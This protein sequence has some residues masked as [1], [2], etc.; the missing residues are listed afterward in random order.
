M[1]PRPHFQEKWLS[2]DSFKVWLGRVPGCSTKAFCNVCQ[3]QLSAEITSLKRHQLSK[4]HIAIV[5]RRQRNNEAQGSA[6]ERVP[7][8]V[9]GDQGLPHAVAYATVLFLVF[10][11]EHNLPFR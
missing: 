5:T 8:D 2:N 1:P 3:K 7:H 6:E 4:Q 11:A 9:N 10:I